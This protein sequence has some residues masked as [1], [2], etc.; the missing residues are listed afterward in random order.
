MKRR[1]SAKTLK[2]IARKM[3]LILAGLAIFSIVCVLALRWINP[4]TSSVIIERKI[5]AIYTQTPLKIEREWRDYDHISDA[6]KLAVIAAEDQNF[7]FHHGFDVNAILSAFKHN[8]NSDSVRGASTISQQVAKNLFLWT[9]RSWL[10]KGLEVWFTIWIELLWS[11]Q[12][13]LEVYLNIAEWGNGV[14]GAEAASHYY[15]HHS[16]NT[17]TQHEASRLAAILPNPR[18]WDPVNADAFI[19]EKSRWIQQQMV[20]LGETRYLNTLD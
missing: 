6:L 8:A 13:I 3:G 10:R 7:P 11:K 19:L 1:S 20:N 2:N 4:L 17:L 5:S 15:F 16:A 14:F 9:G 18:N 12:R